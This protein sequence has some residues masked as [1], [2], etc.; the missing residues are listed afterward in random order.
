M[1]VEFNLENDSSSGRFK[2]VDVT[3]IGGQP[4]NPPRRSRRAKGV[5]GGDESSA[6]SDKKA[7]GRNSKSS[8]KEREPPFHDAIS[9]EAKLEIATKGLVLGEKSTLDVA[10]GDVRL[11]LG[12]G[13]YAGLASAEGI[14]GEG[15]YTCNV[16]GIIRFT[17]QRALRFSDGVW[18]SHDT[19][20]LLKTINLAKGKLM[21][22]RMPTTTSSYIRADKVAPIEAGENPEKL[23]GEGKTDPRDALEQDGFLM[24]RVVLTR[25]PRQSKAS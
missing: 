16:D 19:D 14:L 20:P 7:K 2:A 22:L 24:R 12:Q 8:Q 3:G 10:I 11:K 6:H 1:T 15:T 4:I 21:L 18:S 17:W 23:W 25:P 9:H 13:G 5:K